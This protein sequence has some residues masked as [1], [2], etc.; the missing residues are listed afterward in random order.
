MRAAGYAQLDAPSPASRAA[1]APR[2][3]AP[4][5]WEQQT[6]PQPHWPYRPRATVDPLP[7]PASAQRPR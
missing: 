5:S 4:H 1:P 3:S 2:A 7:A 6:P